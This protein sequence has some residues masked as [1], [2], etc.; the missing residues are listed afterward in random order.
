MAQFRIDQ[1]TPGAGTP[2]VSRHDL[3]VGE[4][5]TF[6]A[7]LP[8][9]GAGVSYLWEITD[10]VGSTATLSAT[11]GTSVTI[12]A[13]GLITAPCGF[14]VKLT[15]NDNGVITETT[16]ICSVRG[17]VS[18]LRPLLFGETAPKEAT[19]ASNIPDDST[20]NA[21]YADRAGTGT[22]GQNWRGWGEWPWEVISRLEAVAAPTVSLQQAVDTQ[23]GV[24]VTV[25]DATKLAIVSGAGTTLPT[26]ALETSATSTG[27]VLQV[28]NEGSGAMAKWSRA[29]VP[30]LQIDSAGDIGTPATATAGAI[31]RG[32]SVTVGDSGDAS[33]ISAP[34]VGQ[35]LALR[36]G[37]GG[38]YAGFGFGGGRGG[39]TRL[40]A[41]L[42]G[43]EGVA[44][45]HAAGNLL[46]GAEYEDGVTQVGEGGNIILW[47]GKQPV[48]FGG[49]PNGQIA[50]GAVA[51]ISLS[52]NGSVFVSA[53]DAVS[54]TGATVEISTGAPLYVGT[55]GDISVH[56]S[57]IFLGSGDG[58]SAN[59][60]TLQGASTGLS[61][62]VN[63]ATVLVMSDTEVTVQSGVQLKVQQGSAAAPAIADVST[64][65]T[66]IF[67]SGTGGADTVRVSIAGSYKIG[68]ST[69]SL[70][71][72]TG[73][74]QDLGLATNPWRDIYVSGNVD[75]RDVSVDGAALDTHT[76]NI[77]NPHATSI[78]N[79][80]AGTLAQLNTA[81]SDADVA[82]NADLTSHTTNT[83]NPHS[84]SIANIGVGTLAQLNAAVSD[85]TLSDK[86]IIITETT[87]AR[88]LSDTDNGALI[89]CTNVGGCAISVPPLSAGVSVAIVG[90][91]PASLTIEAGAG[92]TLVARPSAVFPLQALERW[93]PIVVTVLSATNA[94]VYGDLA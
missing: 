68:I 70:F 62:E 18:G 60:A 13:S 57:K 47:T 87:T 85:A 48:I 53:T 90:T 89:L 16:R 40:R 27:V 84:T 71:P 63:S 88:E 39:D 8:A 42:G 33:A 65:T 78:A 61:L 82:N 38:D 58:A 23:A 21:V 83:A 49:S 80:G 46:L 6:T 30:V 50:V 59:Q 73:S 54:L 93:S 2:G 94:L 7:T 41:G 37:K 56:S 92:M 76:A 29:G 43:A 86:T 9:P 79:V 35:E 10:A 64:P 12:G 25:D 3:V 66:G 19:L 32:L 28:A 4:V 24:Q 51:D 72:N 15:A 14:K 45:A 31:A 34:G 20:D 5:I 67:F 11:T 17:A 44:S 52:S 91:E 77:A 55:L 81:I 69:S 75:G 36:A 22:P 26:V 1:A 74:T